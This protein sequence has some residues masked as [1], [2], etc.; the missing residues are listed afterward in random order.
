MRPGI[1]VEWWDS[2]LETIASVVGDRLISSQDRYSVV[3]V[4][5]RATGKSHDE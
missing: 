1:H 2:L 3:R 5:C 4:K